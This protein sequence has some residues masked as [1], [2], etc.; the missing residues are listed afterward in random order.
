[1]AAT[2][3]ERINTEQQRP[4]G[5]VS[6]SATAAQQHGDQQ[7]RVPRLLVAASEI[8][9]RVIVCLAALAIVVWALTRVGFAVIPVIIALLLSTLFVPP[10]RALQARGV[11]RTLATTIVFAGGILLISALIAL[12]ASGVAS[13]AD[14]LS[15]QVSGG[16]DELGTYVADLPFGLDEQE[17][18]KQ[19]DTIDDRVRENSDSIRNGVVSGAAAAGQIL[20]GLAIVLTVLFFFI[21]DGAGMWNWF[22]RL[23]PPARRPALDELGER[24]WTV[25]SAYVKGVV[26]VAL[27]DAVGIGLGLL[28]IGVP[29]V[30]P[31]AV[32]TFVLAFIP[33]VGA[34]AAGAAAV[35]VALVA[36]GPVAALLVLGLVVLVQQLESNVLYPWIV[37]RTVELHPV[38]VLLAVT[39]GGLLYGIVGAALAVPIAVVASAAATTIQH[40]S[41]HGEVAVGPP[42][43]QDDPA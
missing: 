29:L 23:F 28:I 6:A 8:S 17:V 26:F 27:V 12:V 39:V 10:A 2:D 36:E 24:S 15:D 14:S 38:A 5:A 3:R 43:I 18:Q 42:P 7:I 40:H 25:L 37:G 33:I 9:W 31:L 4:A 34:I 11:P 35:L 21:K 41:V 32:L 22:C 19:I 13:E 16:A 20:G 30:L 1:M